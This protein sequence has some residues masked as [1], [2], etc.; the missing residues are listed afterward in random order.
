MNSQHSKQFLTNCEESNCKSLNLQKTINISIVLF[1][2]HSHYNMTA[3]QHH[4]VFC[5]HLKKNIEHDY[6]DGILFS[7]SQHINGNKPVTVHHIV[8][9]Y[10]IKLTSIFGCHLHLKN[11]HILDKT[12]SVPQGKA[13][14]HTRTHTLIIVRF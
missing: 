8:Q 1:I 14:T 4:I 11:R 6:M 3:S 13:H 9:Q 12:I 2:Y 5:K 7:L 10:T